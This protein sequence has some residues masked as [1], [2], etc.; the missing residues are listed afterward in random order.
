M[1]TGE[2]LARL[3]ISCVSV[4]APVFSLVGSPQAHQQTPQAHQKLTSSPTIMRTTSST[5]TALACMLTAC[6]S[7]APPP[8]PPQQSRQY[9]SSS[10]QATQALDG[11]RGC[12]QQALTPLMMHRSTVEPALSVAAVAEGLC[13]RQRTA[14]RDQLANDNGA[15]RFAVIFAD[16][17]V[18]TVRKDQINKAAAQV[19]TSR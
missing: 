18:D 8:A 3:L 4:R 17:Y 2:Q 5:L 7:S 1:A 10:P 9:T 16:S 11:Y 19:M 6:A 15:D 13:I 14:L 12:I